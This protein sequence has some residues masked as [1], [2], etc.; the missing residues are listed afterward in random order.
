MFKRIRLP[1]GRI[2]TDET[3]RALYL[4]KAAEANKTTIKTIE[5]YI[6]NG[7]GENAPYTPAHDFKGRKPKKEKSQAIGHRETF[8][9]II[10]G[11]NDMHLLMNLAHLRGVQPSATGGLK[12]YVPDQDGE[13][14]EIES[15]E[16]YES[17]KA[18]LATVATVL[19]APNIP[20]TTLTVPAASDD[21]VE[22][23]G[24]TV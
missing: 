21:V 24:V 5:E 2:P 6:N 1:I 13:L 7:A 23:S 10:D 4:R 14:S 19:A 9:E 11:M 15:P 3:K 12:L 18:R 20:F 22:S 16:S 8:V 17:F